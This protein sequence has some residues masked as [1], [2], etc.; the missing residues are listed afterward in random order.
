MVRIFAFVCILLSLFPAT[1]LL[2]EG[3]GGFS[4]SF[5]RIGLGARGMAMGN[6]QVASAAD[7][8]GVY[9]NPAALPSL[10]DRQLALSYSNMSLDRKFNFVGFS[11]PLPPY[12]GA[13]VGWIS[14]GVGNIRAYNSNGEDVG[15]LEHGLHAF[16]GAFAVKVIALAQADGNLTNLPSDLINIGV[17]VKFLREGISDTEEFKYNGSGL[18]FDFGLL[19]NLHRNF[20]LGYQARDINSSLSSNTNDIFERGS[21]LKNAFPLVQKL[22][23]FFRTPLNGLALAYDFEWSDKG[24]EKHHLGAELTTAIAAGRAGY[25]S[26]HFTLGGGL[27]FK[28]SKRISMKL[29][30]AFV[31]DVEDEGISHVFSWQFL[32]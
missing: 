31:D 18:G 26:D 24:E 32:F 1:S 7:G 19:L 30:Y 22:G 4:G 3:N 13:A 2:A 6:A 9:Y 14:S 29:D 8:Y 16:Y 10:S 21:D 12:A 25:D 15:E 11:L 23:A 28:A 5:L 17:A 20:S 27:I